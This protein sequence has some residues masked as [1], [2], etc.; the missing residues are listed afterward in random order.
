MGKRK[1]SNEDHELPAR[2][3]KLILNPPSPA[4]FAV[5]TEV[6]ASQRQFVRSSPELSSP[7]ARHDNTASSPSMAIIQSSRYANFP[8][9]RNRIHSCLDCEPSPLANSRS[10]SR[11]KDKKKFE[12][13]IKQL[14]GIFSS[15]LPLS[16]SLPLT[17]LLSMSSYFLVYTSVWVCP[18]RVCLSF[19]FVSQLSNCFSFYI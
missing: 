14:Q 12:E 15:P 8:R 17:L 1:R 4:S 6:A 18:S 9:I 5:S 13:I 16:L 19:C 7:R 10:A 3:R 2:K 11:R